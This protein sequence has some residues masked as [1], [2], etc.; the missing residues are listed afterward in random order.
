[1]HCERSRKPD[2]YKIHHHCRR[3]G[4]FDAVLSR[5]FPLSLTAQA[6][7]ARRSLRHGGTRQRSLCD[8][9]EPLDTGSVRSLPI[10]LVLSSD[11]SCSALKKTQGTLTERNQAFFGLQRWSSLWLGRPHFLHTKVFFS[12]ALRSATL[13]ASFSA[14]SGSLHRCAM[15]MSS[16]SRCLLINSETSRR[17]NTGRQNGCAVL[18]QAAGEY[19]STTLLPSGISHEINIML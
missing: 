17:R 10:T 9:L 16:F 19:Y 18:Q 14:C 7:S 2:S 6:H 13:A 4:S 12:S 3:Y 1:M 8:R 5:N 11:V 15:V